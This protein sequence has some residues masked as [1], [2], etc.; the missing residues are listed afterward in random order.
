MYLCRL[1]G[2]TMFNTC[3]DTENV[4]EYGNFCF[5]CECLFTNECKFAEKLFF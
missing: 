3:S 5:D 4:S 1:R 2:L